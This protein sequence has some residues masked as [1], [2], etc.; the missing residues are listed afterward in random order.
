MTNQAGLSSIKNY[1]QFVENF[2]LSE[3][4]YMHNLYICVWCKY[5]FVY[6]VA[7]QF[8]THKAI[9]ENWWYH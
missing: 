2:S 7:S 4:T 8:T 6:V 3:E 9:L 1:N 5:E